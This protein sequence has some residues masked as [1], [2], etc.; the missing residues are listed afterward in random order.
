MLIKRADKVSFASHFPPK[1]YAA[2][3]GGRRSWRPPENKIEGGIQVDVSVELYLVLL[4][5]GML[6]AL[7]LWRR[8]WIRVAVVRAV[9]ERY[10]RLVLERDLYHVFSPVILAG[11][12]GLVRID[13]LLVSPFGVVAVQL[14][15]VAEL[16][17]RSGDRS[18]VVDPF[19]LR[20]LAFNDRRCLSELAR[21]LVLTPAKVTLLTLLLD[22]GSKA[23][24]ERGL[25]TFSMLRRWLRQRKPR[26]LPIQERLRLVSRLQ[27]MQRQATR[28][29]SG[30]RR[31]ADGKQRA[32][33]V[34]IDAVRDQ[35]WPR[36]RSSKHNT[37][38]HSDH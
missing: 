15:R 8:A 9:L 22:S 1:K 28:L 4:L 37:V 6:L 29:Y 30:E 16:F 24:A 31:P 38:R 3:N 19:T 11:E 32:Q 34:S 17:P 27:R 14:R 26:C 2:E 20:K 7:I 33:V 35:R 21:Q 13:Y 10:L 5:S 36:W 25:M 23:D 12:N 18:G